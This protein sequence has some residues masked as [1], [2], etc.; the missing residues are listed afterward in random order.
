MKVLFARWPHAIRAAREVADAC[1]FDPRELSY[2][3]LKETVPEGWS[4]QEY[5]TELTYEG[6]RWRYPDGVPEKVSTAIAKELAMIE[7]LD[8]PGIF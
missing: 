4:P 6:A 3:D 8:I 5:L 1:D 2:E 7:K